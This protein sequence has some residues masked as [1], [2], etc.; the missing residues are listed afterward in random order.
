MQANE[1]PQHLSDAAFTWPGG[2]A[3][4]ALCGLLA[5]AAATDLKQRRIPNRLVMLGALSA[6]LQQA[7]L[8]QGLHPAAWTQA[9][10]PGVASGALAAVLMLLAAGSLWRLGLWGAGDAKWLTVLAAHSG[11]ALVPA[12]LLWTAIA[13]GVLALYW[14]VT[15]RPNPMPYALA[16]AGGELVLMGTLAVP[17]STG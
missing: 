15:Q 3:L 2:L 6:L 8:P 16:I 7:L 4:A 17:P 1:T 10:T 5:F 13:G 12:L 11:P 9:G 14:K